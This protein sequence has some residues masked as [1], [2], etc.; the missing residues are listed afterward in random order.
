M[1]V[2]TLSAGAVTLKD[3]YAVYSDDA[4]VII[5][6]SCR[7]SVEAATEQILKAAEGEHP[8]YGVNT[9]FGKLA[10]LKIAPEDI[11]TLQRN[12]ILSHCCGVGE[13]ISNSMARFILSLKPI[14]LVR[15]RR[16]YGGASLNSYRICCSKGS[17]L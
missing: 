4:S 1:S 3:L 15:G 5:S 9:G 6:D 7:P 11:A 2:L 13:R 8:I 16:V 14:S 17:H 12:L 10:S